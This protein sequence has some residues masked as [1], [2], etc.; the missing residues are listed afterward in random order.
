LKRFEYS[1]KKR[2]KIK[3]L[4]DFPHKNL[5]LTPYVSK[6]QREMPIYDLFAV[7]NHEGY[8]SG[9]HYYAFAKH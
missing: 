4:V 1:D 6:L 3:K 2:A 5:N 9:G 8:L 7:C